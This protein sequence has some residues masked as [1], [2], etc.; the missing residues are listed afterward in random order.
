MHIQTFSS[1]S[2]RRP[3]HSDSMWML[4][5]SSLSSLCCIATRAGVDDLTTAPARRFGHGRSIDLS[6][7]SAEPIAQSGKG[8]SFL[9]ATKRAFV[10]SLRSPAQLSSAPTDNLTSPATPASSAHSHSHSHSPSPALRRCTRG[11]N[12]QRSGAVLPL[13]A[14]VRNDNRGPG[15]P[16]NR[17]SC[18][19]RPPISPISPSPPQSRR[20]R[21]EPLTTR[22]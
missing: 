5:L 2:P 10:L 1:S 20:A 11:G 15:T 17:L 9:E 4:P 14:I 8:V 21:L 13:T 12:G 19:P 3:N 22:P 16:S 6:S 7:T 18:L